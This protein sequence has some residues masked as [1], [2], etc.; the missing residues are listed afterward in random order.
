MVRN[1][2]HRGPCAGECL[3]G[4]DAFKKGNILTGAPATQ[5][6]VAEGY[7]RACHDL[8]EAWRKEISNGNTKPN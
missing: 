5:E 2:R 7:F 3:C 8:Y 4:L 1:A 6:E